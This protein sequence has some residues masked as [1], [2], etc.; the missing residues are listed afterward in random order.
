MPQDDLTGNQGKKRRLKEEN[1]VLR[2]RLEEAEQTLN[3]IRSGEVDALVIH[4][5]MGETVYAL[6]G[7][8]RPY[9]IFFEQ[10]AEGAATLSLDGT[11]IYTNKSLSNILTMKEGA[12]GKSITSF[13]TP[14]FRNEMKTLIKNALNC[15]TDGEIPFLTEDGRTIPMQLSLNSLHIGGNKFVCL[16][17]VDLT[18]QKRAERALDEAMALLERRVADRTLELERTQEALQKHTEDLMRS[19]AVLCSSSRTLPLMT[20]RNLFV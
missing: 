11:I 20:C 15:P 18:E 5:E 19:N 7:A 10:M 3:A 8:E 1:D 4:G 13:V 14:G 2:S 6:E 9:R 17:A 12:L 16:T